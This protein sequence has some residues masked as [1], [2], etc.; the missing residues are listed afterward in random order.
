[1][2]HELAFGKAADISEAVAPWHRYVRTPLG[3]RRPSVVFEAVADLDVATLPPRI[4][5]EQ[6]IHFL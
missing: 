1:M 3:K 6:A 2:N 4:S 5:R